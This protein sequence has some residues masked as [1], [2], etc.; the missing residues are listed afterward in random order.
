MV[1]QMKIVSC[2][3][4]VLYNPDCTNFL[5]LLDYKCCPLI[6]CKFM[7]KETTLHPHLPPIILIINVLETWI[8][9]P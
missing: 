8:I 6:L 3:R 4:S 1:G 9:M 5:L 2:L 7:Y